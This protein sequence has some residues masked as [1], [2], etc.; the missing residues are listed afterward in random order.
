MEKKV[1][2]KCFICKGKGFFTGTKSDLM[3]LKKDLGLE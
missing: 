1:K 2:V 3:Q